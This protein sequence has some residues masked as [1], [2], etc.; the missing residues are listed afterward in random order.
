MGNFGA[1]ATAESAA[2]TQ[3]I[4][5][6]SRADC[7]GLEASCVSPTQPPFTLFLALELF[8]FKPLTDPL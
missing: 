6:V 8:N 1:A 7:I 2:P 5:A 3:R 4:A